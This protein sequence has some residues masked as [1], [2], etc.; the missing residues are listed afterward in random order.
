MPFLDVF[1][2]KC[3]SIPDCPDQSDELNCVFVQTDK[4]YIKDHVPRG[5]EPGVKPM[6]VT[7]SAIVLSIVN[8]DTVD[9]KFT[10][11]FALTV[12]W[13]DER[14]QYQDLNKNN[15]LNSV[16]RSQLQV[17]WTPLIMMQNSL[18]M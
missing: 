14:L 13:Y 4:T 1:S 3:N 12:Q 10:L 16:S 2:E 17:M 7:I 5:R 18:G 11:D 9:L 8:V 15:V 6:E